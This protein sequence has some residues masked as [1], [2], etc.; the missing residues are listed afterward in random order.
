MKEINKLK[1]IKYRKFLQ[2]MK[3]KK[4]LKFSLK[5]EKIQNRKLKKKG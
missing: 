4:S 1:N 2:L 3:I 5:E